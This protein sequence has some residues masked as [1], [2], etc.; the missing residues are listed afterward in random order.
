MPRIPAEKIKKAFLQIR[1]SADQ[2]DQIKEKARAMNT[3]V[4]DLILKSIDRVRPVRPQAKSAPEVIALEQ[5]RI[6]ELA[7]IGNNLNQIARW[8]NTYKTSGEASEVL[9]HLVAIEHEIKAAL[10]AH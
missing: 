10:D 1:V 4:T 9:K 5:A 7:K 6:R 8:C 3:T 2:R